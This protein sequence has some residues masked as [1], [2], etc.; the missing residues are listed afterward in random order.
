M[1]CTDIRR[2]KD[3]VAPGISARHQLPDDDIAPFGTDA[4]RVFEEDK[5]RT[6]GVDGAEVFRDKPA[7]LTCEACA[8]ASC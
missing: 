8:S 1:A 7:T 4:W 2:G 3:S 6:D 5:G